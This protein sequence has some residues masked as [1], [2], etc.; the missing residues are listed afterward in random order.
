[1]RWATKKNGRSPNKKHGLRPTNATPGLLWTRG[2][3]AEQ[4]TCKN[5][6]HPPATCRPPQLSRP[7]LAQPTDAFHRHNF[8]P[9]LRAYRASAPSDFCDALSSRRRNGVGRTEKAS[10]LPRDKTGDDGSSLHLPGKT[11]TTCKPLHLHR[12]PS[13]RPRRYSKADSPLM[14]N[15]GVRAPTRQPLTDL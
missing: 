4:N 10:T 12:K 11:T 14:E 15:L 8:S 5:L 1:M 7:I 2:E 3:E 13:K 6:V 9:E